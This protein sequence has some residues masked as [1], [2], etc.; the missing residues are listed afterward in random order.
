LAVSVLAEC[1]V[2]EKLQP[3]GVKQG[4]PKLPVVPLVLYRKPGPPSDAAAAL[5]DYIIEHLN[6]AS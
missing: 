3:L 1:A 2:T 5:S 6:R 4:F